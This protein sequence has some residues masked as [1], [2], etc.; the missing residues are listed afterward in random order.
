MT[1]SQTTERYVYVVEHLDSELEAW[2]ALEYRTAAAECSEN[3]DEFILSSVP[4]SPEFQAALKQDSTI[5]IEHR[6]VESLYETQ[7][8][9][10]CLLDPAASLD[11]TPEDG[12]K[13]RVFLFGGILGKSTPEILT[14][15]IVALLC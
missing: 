11:L 4:T 9:S 2:S 1:Q 10:V 5:Q 7:K 8:S 12:K 13:F 6:C 3:N 15:D 14:D